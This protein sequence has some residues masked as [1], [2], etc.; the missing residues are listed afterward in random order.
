VVLTS[1]GLKAGDSYGAQAW[2]GATLESPQWVPAA[3]GS[4]A[5]FTSQAN[6]RGPPLKHFRADPI[7]VFLETARNRLEQR[8]CQAVCH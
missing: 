1:P 6:R 8:L 2:H 3:D 4:T 7:G 5:P